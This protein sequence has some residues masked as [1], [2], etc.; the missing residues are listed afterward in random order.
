[1]HKILLSLALAT[2]CVAVTAQDLTTTKQAE[3]AGVRQCLS[4]IKELGQ[5]VIKESRHASHDIWSTK[6]VDAR[7]FSS[8]VVKGYSDGDSHVTLVA[9]PDKTG[10]CYGEWR[11]T[12]YWP[13]SCT[14][15]REEIF[16]K[17][18]FSGTLSDSTIF[19]TN[20]EETLSVYLTPQ[21]VSAGCLTTRREVIYYP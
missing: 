1:V 18:K 4:Q 12:A 17:L 7:P 9:G 8:F 15:V 13:K 10:K 3:K 2:F 5:F 20:T 16:G 11:E 19:L 21:S 6:S 14:V